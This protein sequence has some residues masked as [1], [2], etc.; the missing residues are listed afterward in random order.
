MKNK[1]LL[2]GLAAVLL[3]GGATGAYFLLFGSNAADEDA[4]P[5]PAALVELA[6]FL[7]NI[8]DQ[9]KARIEVALAVAPLGL[10][11]VIAADPLLAARL[12]DKILTT[13][14]ARTYEE[15]NSPAGKEEFRKMIRA[16]AQ[17]IITQGEVQEALF[18]DFV[19]Q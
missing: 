8:A 16:S 7:T 2:I 5:E 1:K 12:R 11:E 9:H 4:P 17:E 19:V 6:P 14:A 10:S 3:I 15:L 13:L 18:V